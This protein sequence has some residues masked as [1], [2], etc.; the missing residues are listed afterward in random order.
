MY[1]NDC[2]VRFGAAYLAPLDIR[3][4]FGEKG[5]KTMSGLS[6]G[7]VVSIAASVA[8]VFFVVTINLQLLLAAGILPISIAW[9]GQQ[10]VLITTNLS[11]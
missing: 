8:T 10:S 7:S 6:N 3:R 11:D 5:A 9:G 1:E 2:S 4:G